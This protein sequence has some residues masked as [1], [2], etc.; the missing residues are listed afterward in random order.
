MLGDLRL[1]L[2]KSMAE[3]SKCQTQNG[4]PLWLNPVHLF[5]MASSLT[6]EPVV[7]ASES[8]GREAD[9][10]VVDGF[11]AELEC[12]LEE[13]GSA[14]MRTAESVSTSEKYPVSW[15]DARIFLA[16]FARLTSKEQ[17]ATFLLLL[18]PV[19]RIFTQLTDAAD[20]ERNESVLAKS[21]VSSFLARL[22]TLCVNTFI[23]MSF[24]SGARDELFRVLGKYLPDHVPAASSPGEWFTAD[25]A[26][27]GVF[28]D[29]ADPELPAIS[30]PAN[31]T[32]SHD[33]VQMLQHLLESAFAVGFTTA[34]NDR[35]HLLYAAW[36]ALGKN[37]LWRENQHQIQTV[38]SLPSNLAAV[39]LQ[40]RE[41]VTLVHRLVLRATSSFNPTSTLLK[42]IDQMDTNMKR[43][44]L[45]GLKAEVKLQLKTMIQ[46]ASKLVSLMLQQFVPTDTTVEQ[47][48]PPEVFCI[49]ELCAAYISFSVAAYTR[50]KCDWF[51][52]IMLAMTERAI[53][54]RDRAYSTDSGDNQSVCGSDESNDALV[55]TMERMQDVCDCIG[56]A[57]AHP[58]W[59]DK[60]CQLWEG[61]SAE[62]ATEAVLE[63]QTCLTSLLSV[64]LM[65]ARL[66]HRRALEK[67]LGKGN[68][69]AACLASN[70]WW[71]HRFTPD[72]SSVNVYSSGERKYI[73]DVGA[74]C[75]LNAE[76][77][78]TV[79]TD[80]TFGSRH[81]ATESWQAHSAQRILGKYQEPFRN[82]LAGEVEKAELRAGGEWEVLLAGAL[83][84][85]CICVNSTAECTVVDKMVSSELS[86]SG[87]WL[88]VCASAIS[89]L[90][91]SAAL[92]RFCLCSGGR[93]AH[94]LSSADTSIA[95]FYSNKAPFVESIPDGVSSANTASDAVVLTLG[96]LALYPALPTCDSVASHLMVESSQFKSLR[97]MEASS[98]ALQ[99]LADLQDFLA[100][101]FPE[102]CE[103]SPFVI[104]CIADVL[105]SRATV[106]QDDGSR[107]PSPMLGSLRHSS[108]TPFVC[109]DS[110]VAAG[111]FEPTWILSRAHVHTSSLNASS[112]NP[113]A[114]EQPRQQFLP[115]LLSPFWEKSLEAN[116]RSLVF[117]ADC[118]ASMIVMEWN[119]SSGASFSLQ[120]FLLPLA[121]AL[122]QISDQTLADI[123]R[124]FICKT[125]DKE[126]EHGHLECIQK[127]LCTILA[128]ILAPKENGCSVFTG[129]D[130]I[131]STLQESYDKWKIFPI[132]Q[133]YRIMELM[134]LLACHENKLCQIGEKIFSDLKKQLSLRPGSAHSALENAKHFIDCLLV[135]K[136]VSSSTS[137]SQPTPNSLPSK[138]ILSSLPEKCTFAILSDFH[139]QHWYNCYTCGL[140]SDKGC[141]SLCAVICHQG[142][143]VEYARHSSFFCDCGGEKSPGGQNK[144]KCLA[145]HSRDKAFKIRRIADDGH[146][147]KNKTSDSL[148]LSAGLVAMIVKSF[149][150]QR[151]R[152]ALDEL[153]EKGQKTS[154]T[155]FMF[156]CTKQHFDAWK[157][158]RNVSDG[159]FS[160]DNDI[161]E[162]SDA[163]S[164]SL[165]NRNASA[166]V[167]QLKAAT[168]VSLRVSISGMI[169]T[170]MSNDSAT[171]RA[172]R[173]RLSDIGIVRSVV[174]SDSRGRIV[175]AEPCGLVFCNGFPIARSL[176][177]LSMASEVPFSR[178]AMHIMCSIE[179]GVQAVGVKFAQDRENMVLVW[180]IDESR[181]VLMNEDL[182]DAITMSVLDCGA[183]RADS[184]MIVNAHW[185]H[186]SGRTAILGFRQS[187]L[188][189]D[190]SE[191]DDKSK[192][193]ASL[194]LSTEFCTSAMRDF[195]IVPCTKTE[196]DWNGEVSC[197]CVFVLMDNGFVYSTKVRRN[198]CGV[199]DADD[200]DPLNQ[201]QVSSNENHD[202]PQSTRKG[203]S[204]TYLD[205]SNLLLYQESNSAV[206]VILLDESGGSR[207]IFDLLPD[208]LS[209]E[210]VEEGSTM[211]VKGPY[212]HWTQLGAIYHESTCAFR[213]S[214]C[215]HS[216]SGQQ[217]LLCLEFDENETRVQ[218][219]TRTATGWFDPPQSCEG[220]TA[221]SA[222]IHIKNVGHPSSCL[223]TQFVERIF[224]CTL[225][226]NGC[227]QI[228]A[229]AVTSLLGASLKP[230]KDLATSDGKVH[231]SDIVAEDPSFNILEFEKLTNL[232]ESNYLTFHAD[233]LGW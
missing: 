126:T 43:Y 187:L 6:S 162:S 59:L 83:T 111:N 218:E 173:S 19:D 67:C 232:T 79:L 17:G 196:V 179:V 198:A 147:G 217:L 153:F 194:S 213:L 50:P 40:L 90:V 48:V 168:F 24:G 120:S 224:L 53:R 157:S 99:V 123:V 38:T 185:L 114:W 57:P 75:G 128:F 93:I 26:F 100:A 104:E 125:S 9:V 51:S 124:T 116:M 95:D 211:S 197:W 154:W 4:W 58:D 182:T 94:P 177:T 155:R 71:L 131:L 191:S 92:L 101:K 221:F 49:L 206:V 142:H 169:Q 30:V 160:A 21:G 66:S 192:L 55:D 74:I 166:T 85:A 109:L 113:W 97:G 186:G 216:S 87:H 183:K 35:C 199:Y 14:K 175:Y 219:I 42:F 25:N 62:E 214:C 170:K 2:Y 28:T 149:F 52:S 77:S 60:D 106:H 37:D 22:V 180:G 210:C 139:D 178:S 33:G 73:T 201:L 47:D 108:S 189:F 86:S 110:V 230:S 98:V 91:P 151:G 29:W 89:A 121:N 78:I 152:V 20:S 103:A 127:S 105:E 117:F 102:G 84:S 88:G 31:F 8:V 226:L 202:S 134:L 115:R 132:Q 145:P 195:A 119:E 69:S 133:R 129:C 76:S 140:T 36:N 27:L 23:V 148:V 158:H 174:D 207:G 228:H 41:D 122:N 161:M 82:G 138:T 107:L 165:C 5:F 118:V 70:L 190:F 130:I 112:P 16:A 1:P 231:P 181:M 136:S 150:P 188:L 13:F 205:Q 176:S 54:N 203:F 63:A 204:L 220:A 44:S 32:K 45:H 96:T 61:V 143:D 7:T 225:S 184:D 39:V 209:A 172:K 68:E 144:C 212:T 193:S 223:H 222:P 156:M 229:E 46:K 200:F 11:V 65:R 64:G 80:S 15:N 12:T 146:V 135:I 34:K 159:I 233:M 18:I 164:K 163:W 141:C 56:A 137:V 10:F 227:L 81:L 167:R 171:D 3:L 208:D 215:A 72:E